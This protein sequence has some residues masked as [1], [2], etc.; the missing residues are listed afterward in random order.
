MPKLSN[1]SSFATKVF[2]EQSGNMCIFFEAK[3]PPEKPEAKLGAA[4]SRCVCYIKW[5]FAKSQSKNCSRAAAF[6]LFVLVH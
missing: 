5:I 1:N 2:S 3:T 6:E 4:I